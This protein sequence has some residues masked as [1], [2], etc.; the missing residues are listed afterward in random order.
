MKIIS[1]LLAAAAL[2]SAATA[3]AATFDVSAF[4]N[5]SSGG[6]PLASIALTNGRAFTVA[7]S[8]DDLW[9]AGALPR[10]SDGSGLVG[11][12]FATATDDSGQP[13]GT[14]IG[15]NFGG[16]TQDGFTAPYGSLVGRLNG[17]YTLLGANYSGVATGNGTLE[18]F[19]WDSNNGDN[20]GSIRFDI[21]AA[22]PE[23]ETWA[24]LLAGFAMVGV[25]VRRRGGKPVNA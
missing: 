11:N 14:L 1:A 9:S 12:R 10:F 3:T 25:A 8:T 19:Y 18:L 20:T 22:V 6:S 16:Y 15:V 21:N 4:A 13:V 17:V 5:S 23:P 7:S 24:L 2:A